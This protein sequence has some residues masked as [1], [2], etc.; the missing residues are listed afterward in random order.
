MK[1]MEDSVHERLDRLWIE[2]E[3]SQASGPVE[4]P[5]CYRQGKRNSEDYWNCMEVRR[6]H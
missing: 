6:W 2:A 1:D 5:G 4:W 3:V